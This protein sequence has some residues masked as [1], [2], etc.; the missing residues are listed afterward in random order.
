MRDELFAAAR[1]CAEES[2][3]ASDAQNVTTA[4]EL[5]RVNERR[6]FTH[7]E[8]S[9]WF[10]PQSP[11]GSFIRKE[12]G[13]EDAE[14]AAE[15]FYTAAKQQAIFERIVETALFVITLP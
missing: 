3:A 14:R 11:Y 13:D 10:S 5:L 12:M 15:L 4:F 8:V 6:V 2:L 7:S 9:R 1:H